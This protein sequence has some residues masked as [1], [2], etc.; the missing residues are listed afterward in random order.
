MVGV[1]RGLARLPQVAVLDAAHP[2]RDVEHRDAQ[3]RDGADVEQV[4]QSTRPAPGDARAA[5]EAAL[6]AEGQDEGHPAGPRPELGLEVSGDGGRGDGV[7]NPLIKVGA[8]PVQ[9]PAAPARASRSARV[10]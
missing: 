4:D 3:R 1:G 7:G 6:R 9:H 8:V 10:A 2:D 5:R